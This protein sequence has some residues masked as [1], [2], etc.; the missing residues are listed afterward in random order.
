MMGRHFNWL[1]F[2]LAWSLLLGL[3]DIARAQAP[4]PQTP[5]R[6]VGQFGG[7]IDAIA[8]Q[9]HYA[10]IGMG[11]RM[12]VLDVANPAQPVV[13]GQTAVLPDLVKGLA[14]A[15]RYV[16]IA[17]DGGG[18]RIADVFD[19]TAPTLVGSFTAAD[20]AES[21]LVIGTIAYIANG[22]DGLV[23]L[24][25]S[26]PAAPV[27][28]GSCD[29]FGGHVYEVAIRGS[30]AYLA[31]GEGGLRIVDI[32]FMDSPYEI[33]SYAP[34]DDVLGVGIVGSVA[35]LATGGYDGRLYVI[36]VADPFAPAEIG[37]YDIPGYYA[38]AITIAGNTAYVAAYGDGL[39]IFDIA[40][41]S[42]PVEVGFY[43]GPS[44][45]AKD[46][47][48]AGSI[49][50]AIGGSDR[51]SILN[52]SRRTAPLEIGSFSGLGYVS[53]AVI[54]SD[55]AYLFA[56]STLRAFDISHPRQPTLIGSYEAPGNIWDV[57]IAGHAA[58]VANAGSDNVCI[59]DV[60]NPAAP[61]EIGRARALEPPRDLAVEDNLLYAAA[62]RSGLR[63]IDVSNPAAAA[64]VGSY[65]T[66]TSADDVAVTGKQAYVAANFDISGGH[67][68]P[69]GLHIVDASAPEH[70][71]AAGFYSVTDGTYRVA[72]SGR[73][74]Y[75][76]KVP[77]LNLSP[78][79][80]GWEDG[81]LFILDVSNSVTPTQVGF[82]PMDAYIQDVLVANQY[83][84]LPSDGDGLSIVSLSNPAAPYLAG[85]YDTPG[86]A[87]SAAMAGNYVFV[88]DRGGGLAVL[89]F[90]APATAFISPA[91][92]GLTAADRTTYTFPA[93]VFTDTAVITHTSRFPADAPPPG[94]L[95]GIDHFF[96][97]TAVYSG[98]DRPAQPVPGQ[99]YT[100]TVQ[101]AEAE[102]G[103][104]IEDTLAL[105][106]WDGNQWI[107]EP[108]STVDVASN[109]VTAS[110][111]HLA[112][113]WAVLGETERAY[114]PIVGKNR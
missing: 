42:H 43:D 1:A 45:S 111:D 113:L 109:T 48:V 32:S 59:I 26:N 22:I 66:P 95:A 84:Y 65:Y 76:T 64:E 85:F 4:E 114:L 106:W 10:Y 27:E 29:I 19:P 96:D 21:V 97:V 104:A 5:V 41:P 110:P 102:K 34:P 46:V 30:Y 58:Y 89:W 23:I 98:T 50:Y 47:A 15:G 8:V 80:G 91:G 20:K 60:S 7:V 25:I 35:Y 79:K 28:I 13:L 99:A 54:A 61:L 39:R 68:V 40:T 55:T 16:Y 77:L 71:A 62:A 73:I 38:A 87:E 63:L 78:G 88:A 94:D 101:Y 49:A 3:P 31:A 74:A 72:V 70:P 18:L 11:P 2:I 56:G 90:A 17:D 33:G 82:Y 103:P 75:V 93:G 53:G 51:L 67:H 37:D 24:D 100:L 14:V 112:S 81:G 83:A 57:A 105:Y 108:S 92:G 69:G 86:Q 36:N 107:K 44:W 9:G 6:L 12:V 52:V